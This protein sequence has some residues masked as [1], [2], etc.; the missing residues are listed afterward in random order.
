MFDCNPIAT[1]M[2]LDAKLS[3]L[4][5]EEVVDLNNYRSLIGSL[6]YLTCTRTDIAFTVNVISG[7]MEDLRH[8]HLKAIKRILKYV[9][10]T[11]DLGLHYTKTNK[12]ELT[13]YVN[14]DWCEDVNDRKSTSGYAI[15]TGDTTFTQ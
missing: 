10:G 2:E 15:F 1:P 13:S 14:D 11:K 7:F 9:K 6:R 8:S 3:K 5:G 4:E 12:F